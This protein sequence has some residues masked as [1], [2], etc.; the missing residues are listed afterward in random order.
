[1]YYRGV[2]D[3]PAN[4]SMDQFVLPRLRSDYLQYLKDHITDI[5]YPR[6]QYNAE[7]TYVDAQIGRLLD[8]IREMGGF[9]DPMIILIGD[10]G[11]A[12]GEHG[13]YFSHMQGITDEI[14]RVPL[15]MRMPGEAGGVRIDSLAQNTDVLPTVLEALDLAVPPALEGKSLLPLI[16]GTGTAV[17]DFAFIEQGH[18]QAFALYDGRWKFVRNARGGDGR[19]F[20]M[21]SEGGEGRDLSRIETEIAARMKARLLE[22]IHDKMEETSRP[23]P[24]DPALAEK[25]RKLGYIE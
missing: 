14:V 10:H 22:L 24:E 16:R 20:D 7:V 4:R 9:D 21:E 25:L 2:K 3:D 18:R 12:M 6:A 19:L 8:G 11:E 13:I 15:I 17:R 23:V 1:M 5:E